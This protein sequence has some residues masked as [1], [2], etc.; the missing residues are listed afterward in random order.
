MYRMKM[1]DHRLSDIAGDYCRNLLKNKRKFYLRSSE[2][3]GI[4]V[5]EHHQC[6]AKF[7]LHIVEL[8][9]FGIK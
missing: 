7:Q 4:V 3:L 8:K 5:V 2:K 1:V 9:Q 6:G